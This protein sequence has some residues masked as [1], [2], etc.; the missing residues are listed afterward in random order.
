MTKTARVE[1]DGDIVVVAK[2]TTVELESTVKVEMRLSVITIRPDA[3]LRGKLL[4]VAGAMED[5]WEL[6][7]VK[8]AALVEALGS[9]F[10][11]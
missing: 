6:D 10:V 5:D 8:I 4:T 3:V 9:A 2:T 11:D 7:A 1:A